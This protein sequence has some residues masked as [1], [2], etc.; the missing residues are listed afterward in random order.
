VPS[1]DATG[2]I[3]L[4]NAHRGSISQ[5]DLHHLITKKALKRFI[6]EFP[7]YKYRD[8]QWF[9]IFGSDWVFREPEWDV[10]KSATAARRFI[11][12]L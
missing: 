3:V 8:K 9:L 2:E 11:C 10:G 1:G 4:Y 6:R 7:E 12:G 5:D